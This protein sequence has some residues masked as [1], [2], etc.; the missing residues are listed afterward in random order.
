MAE[1]WTLQDTSIVTDA[2]PKHEYTHVHYII[3]DMR[4]GSSTFKTVQ[5]VNFNVSGEALRYLIEV[6]LL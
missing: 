2:T 1:H 5:R 4:L 3:L 6:K